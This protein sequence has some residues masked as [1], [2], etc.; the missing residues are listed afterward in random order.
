MLWGECLIVFDRE[1]DSVGYLCFEVYGVC[2]FCKIVGCKVVWKVWFD[3]RWYDL[4]KGNW[5]V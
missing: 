3:D 4:R 1:F 2:K 5:K